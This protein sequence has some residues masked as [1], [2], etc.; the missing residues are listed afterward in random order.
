MNALLFF[1]ESDLASVIVGA[2]QVV[3]TAIAALIMDK[4]GRKVLLII[5]GT[6]SQHENKVQSFQQMRMQPF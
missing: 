1:Q 2:I 3:F 6:S 5:S 4:A